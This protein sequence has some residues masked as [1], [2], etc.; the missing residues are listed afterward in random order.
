MR[1][2]GSAPL[3]LASSSPFRAR[4]LAAAGLKAI[5]DAAAI[6]EGEIKA[7]FRR[8]KR[9]TGACA[10]ALAE[11]KAKRVS[12]RHPSALVIGADQILDCG[13]EWLDKPRDIEEARAQLQFL[14]GKRHELAT[15]A[16]VISDGAVLWHRVERPSLAMREL[17]D[18]FIEDYLA[19]AGDGVCALVGAYAVEGLGAQLFDRIDGDY[20]AI[21]GLPLLPL[22]GYLR[23]RG[24]I[25]R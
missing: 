20:F 12:L 9:D 23:E 5:V 22:L 21:L 6:D 24:A 13:G 8:E 1:W 2:L 7:G 17:S 16:A 10:A 18:G 14:R 25:A 15:A 4:L 11:A 3:V 19:A